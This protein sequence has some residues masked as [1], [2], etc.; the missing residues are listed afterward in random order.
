MDQW[1]LNLGMIFVNLVSLL[2]LICIAS[3]VLLAGYFGYRYFKRSK[4]EEENQ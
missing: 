4:R 1:G 3:P 2:V